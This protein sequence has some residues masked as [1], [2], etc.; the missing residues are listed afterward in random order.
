MQI[1]KSV[2]MMSTGRASKTFCWQV[3]S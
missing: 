3:L 1:K 2:L